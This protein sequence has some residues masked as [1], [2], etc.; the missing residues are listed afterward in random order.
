MQP[1]NRLRVQSPLPITIPIIAYLQQE[2]VH[3]A[4]AITVDWLPHFLQDQWG[5][6]HLRSA[7]QSFHGGLDRIP[8]YTEA[9]LHADRPAMLTIV[10][11]NDTYPILLK[12]LDAKGVTYKVM[13]FPSEP[14]YDVLVVTELSRTRVAFGVKSLC[15]CFPGMY[16]KG[17]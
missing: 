1:F 7:Q 15:A 13:R 6:Y 12:T 10:K 8:G 9:V 17:F 11:H 3:Y 2:H 4:W 14:A 5:Y 16:L